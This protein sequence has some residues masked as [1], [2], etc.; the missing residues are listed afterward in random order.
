MDS[1]SDLS[2]S[3]SDLAI[4]ILHME[5]KPFALLISGHNRNRRN[6]GGGGTNRFFPCTGRSRALNKRFF[7]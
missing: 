3:Q 5:G 4:A 6:G 7:W 1:H 2:V